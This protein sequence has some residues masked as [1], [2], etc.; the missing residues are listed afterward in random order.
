MRFLSL[1]PLTVCAAS[2]AGTPITLEGLPK[3]DLD[4][5][6]EQAER[7]FEDVLEI[8]AAIDE[9]YDGSFETGSGGTSE[10]FVHSH[11]LKTLLAAHLALSNE[12]MDYTDPPQ[13]TPPGRPPIQ[14]FP[15]LTSPA[16][17]EAVDVSG[18]TGAPGTQEL[19]WFV[20]V[21]LHRDSLNWDDTISNTWLGRSHKR[22]DGEQHRQREDK[23]DQSQQEECKAIRS[24]N[25]RTAGWNSILCPA[26][27][28]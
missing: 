10:Q 15:R 23:Q 18:G 7:L 20:P 19:R 16:I 21:L 9:R 22:Q 4:H 25:W 17:A 26:T 6:R 24:S 27:S 28:S 5:A 8:E 13:N 1:L 2:C 12:H 14:V 3:H 11:A